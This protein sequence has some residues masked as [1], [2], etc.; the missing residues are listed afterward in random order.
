MIKFRNR[1]V[2]CQTNA[3]IGLEPSW[4]EDGQQ[5]RQ[6][7]GWQTNGWRVDPHF[8]TCFCWPTFR[9]GC[10]LVPLV[11]FK[12]RLRLKL[13]KVTL[14]W[15]TSFSTPRGWYTSSFSE[16]VRVQINFAQARRAWSCNVCPL[17]A[18]GGLLQRPPL[19]PGLRRLHGA[20]ESQYFLCPSSSKLLTCR[21]FPPRWRRSTWG[22]RLSLSTAR[23]TLKMLLDTPLGKMLLTNLL[24]RWKDCSADIFQHT[25]QVDRRVVDPEVLKHMDQK[26]EKLLPDAYKLVSSCN[27]M[28][29]TTSA[30][31]WRAGAEH[32]DFSHGDPLDGQRPH[33]HNWAACGQV[34]HKPC[35]VPGHQSSFLFLLRGWGGGRVQRGRRRRMRRRRRW[36]ALQ[37][38]DLHMELLFVILSSDV[39]FRTASQKKPCHGHMYDK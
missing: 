11:F 27:A 39:L 38:Q 25:A 9:A 33:P 28:L 37:V 34:L 17:V 10:K 16:A 36:T 26:L 14:R 7:F 29:G 20:E 13:V 24:G 2:H 32:G 1:I 8:K 6:T 21:S 31:A 3:S 4:G 22:G 30:Q 35:G 18:G 12:T 15:W 23:S 19:R 5:Q